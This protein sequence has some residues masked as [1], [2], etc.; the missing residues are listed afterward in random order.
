MKSAVTTAISTEGRVF[1]AQLMRDIRARERAG[2]NHLWPGA[3][4]WEGAIEG[5]TDHLTHSAGPVKAA[6]KFRAAIASLKIAQTKEGACRVNAWTRRSRSGLFEILT[7]HVAKHPLINKGYE[8]IV[9]R[10][11]ALW[12]RRIG[13]IQGVLGG[14]LAFLSWHAL[15]R[16][17]ERCGVDVFSA[18]GIAGICGTV[19]LLM[20]ESP[21]HLNTE[22]N[23]AF[24][25]MLC[26]GVQR[27]VPKGEKRRYG[28]YDVVTVLYP[29][30]EQ[31][32]KKIE[33]GSIIN[34]VVHAYLKT[35]SSDPRGYA[36]KIPVL[37]FRESDYVSRQ[38]VHREKQ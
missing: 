30:E 16:M 13:A 4:S 35:D 36:D 22:I 23:L 12:L 10:Q 6:K 2:A 28:F 17:H 8:G 31:H 1:V 19:G 25:G 7:W 15:A 37:P 29:D 18:S 32:P 9:V 38:L 26:L 3:T 20:R 21:K 27:D 11:H 33:Q 14:T 5:F 24:E 34:N